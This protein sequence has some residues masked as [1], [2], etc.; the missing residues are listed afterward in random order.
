M[1]GFESRLRRLEGRGDCPLCEEAHA[2]LLESIVS[3][4]PG[5]S[6]PRSC[7][8]CGRDV[9]LTIYEIDQLLELE[10]GGA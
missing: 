9:R 6:T 2:A 3:S 1:R 7:E 5:S 8:G 10:G 4:T